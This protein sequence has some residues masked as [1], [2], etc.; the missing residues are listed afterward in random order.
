MTY[1]LDVRRVIDAP[2]EVV[3]R[4]RTD[5][6]FERKISQMHDATSQLFGEVAVGKVR[7]AEWGPNESRC[8]VTQT[9]L[10]VDE[11]RGVYSELLEV[12]PSPVYETLITETMLPEDGKTLF[13]FHVEGFPT[14]EERDMH[15]E[16]Y[17]IV[18]DRLENYLTSS[19]E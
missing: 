2:R 9:F 16:G 6:D 7:V 13:H 12:P 1:E 8:R 10:E 17:N 5:I 15:R 3:Y 14:T 18:L 4:A 19:R 11:N